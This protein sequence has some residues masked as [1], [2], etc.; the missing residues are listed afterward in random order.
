MNLGLWRYSRHPNYFGEILFWWSV[1][2]FGL[3]ANPAWFWTVVGPLA[4]VVMFLAASIPMLD[5][6]SRERRPLFSEYADR[7]SALI[8]WPP[9]PG[10]GA[11]A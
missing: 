1:W 8:P 4:I 9:R 3:A 5:D 10:K 2:L 7:T 11:A 6:R